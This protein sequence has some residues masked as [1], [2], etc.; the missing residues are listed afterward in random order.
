MREKKAR[1]IVLTKSL[2]T[3]EYLFDGAAPHIIDQG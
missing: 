1:L 3:H 2:D